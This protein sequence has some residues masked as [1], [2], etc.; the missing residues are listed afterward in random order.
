MSS[1]GILSNKLYVTIDIPFEKAWGDLSSD[2]QKQIVSENI[3]LLDTDELISELEHRGFK[4][5]KKD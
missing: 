1:R 5:I 4:G 2:D 3:S